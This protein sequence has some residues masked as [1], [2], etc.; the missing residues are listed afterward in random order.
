[1]RQPTAMRPFTS[2]PDRFPSDGMKLSEPSVAH[3]LYDAQRLPDRQ[4]RHPV[5]A[6]TSCDSCLAQSVCFHASALQLETDALALPAPLKISRR[7][8]VYR[9]GD[10]FDSLYVIEP[11]RSKLFRCVLTDGSTYPLSPC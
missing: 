11:D 1:M 4:E 3:T 7:S 8:V 9:A 6:R 5:A 10:T 2:S